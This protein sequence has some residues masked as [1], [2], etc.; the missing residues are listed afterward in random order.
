MIYK[1]K[2]FGCSKTDIEALLFR[3]YLFDVSTESQ[4]Y[5][6]KA[7]HPQL[8]FCTAQS[9]FLTAQSFPQQFYRL[10]LSFPFRGLSTSTRVVYSKSLSLI[11]V[12]ETVS[13]GPTRYGFRTRWYYSFNPLEGPQNRGVRK[14]VAKCVAEV[15]KGV[16]KTAVYGREGGD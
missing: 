5:R 10:I 2:W 6:L 7:F 16:P 9:Y 11:R 4:F 8:K 3:Q 12:C 15:H 14:A 1:G 13:G